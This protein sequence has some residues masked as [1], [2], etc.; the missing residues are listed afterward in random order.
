[1]W[2]YFCNS[3]WKRERGSTEG[4]FLPPNPEC[5]LPLVFHPQRKA[6]FLCPKSYLLNLV[7]CLTEDCGTPHHH[8]VSEHC[9]HISMYNHI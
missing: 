2:A 5:S 7:Y 1:M 9:I 4:E 8:R 3:S 6:V